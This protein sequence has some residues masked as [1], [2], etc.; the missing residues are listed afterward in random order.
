MIKFAVLSFPGTNCEAETVRAFKR[1]GMQAEMVL[2]ND[3][4]LKTQEGLKEFDGYCI[5]GGFSYEDRGRSGIVSAQDPVMEVVKKEADKG[6]VVLG[7]CNGAQV[8]VETG[9]VPGYSNHALGMALAWN[10]MRQEGE[11]VDTGFYN[12]WCYLKNAAPKNRSPFNDFDE[13]LHVPFAHGEGRFVMSDALMEKME[14]NGQIVFKYCDEQGE[15]SEK[16]PTTPNGAKGAVAAICNPAGNVMAIMPHPERDPNEEGH[17]IFHSIRRW[18][19]EKKGYTDFSELGEGETPTDVRPME[20]FDVEVY[21]RLIITDNTERTLEEA[22]QR[23][24]MEAELKRFEFFGLNLKS[25][26]KATPELIES[27][28]K[29]GE[30]ANLNKHQVYINTSE[31][32]FGYDKDKGLSLTDLNLDPHVIVVDH[33]DTVGEHKADALHLHMG[34]SIDSVRFGVLWQFVETSEQV[35]QQVID[36]FI[37]YNPYSMYLMQ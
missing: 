22:I 21:V 20:S 24:G 18:M 8:L 13:M 27:L 25:G 7:I 29:T 19:E 11:V 16:Y 33:Q 36:S 5:A 1:A 2:W 23:K 15:V 34:D 32:M 17:A 9:L 4:R 26:E 14:E 28:M 37:L 31:G 3:E 30:L 35:T 10:E 6:K 12:A